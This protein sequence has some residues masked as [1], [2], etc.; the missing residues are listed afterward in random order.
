MREIHTVPG[1]PRPPASSL[2]ARISFELRRLCIPGHLLGF[3]Y[4]A[5][6]L[7]RAIPDQDQLRLLTKN[8]YPDTGRRFG[9]TPGSVERDVRFAICK[10]WDRGGR[11][12]LEHMADAPLGRRPPATEF[13]HIVSDFIRRTS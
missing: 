9:A 12:T 4:L 8:L 10:S 1:P 7:G 3:T 5:Y 13:L 6:M 2:P 11:A